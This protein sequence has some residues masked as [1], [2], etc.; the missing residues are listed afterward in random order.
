MLR[1]LAEELR[2]LSQATISVPPTEKGADGTLWSKGEAFLDFAS[3]D[4]LEQ[5]S[6]QRLIRKYVHELEKE[7]IAVSATRTSGGFR[8]VHQLVEERTARFLG[9]EQSVTLTNLPQVALTLVTNLC[10]E[11][12]V[13]LCE[14][15][16]GLPIEDAAY[17]VDAKYYEFTISDPTSY[18]SLLQRS[19]QARR[20]IIFC[21]SVS[22]Y[23][24]ELNPLLPLLSAANAH[25]ALL[26]VDE[27][28]ALGICGSRGAGYNDLFES[29]TTGTTSPLLLQLGSFRRGLGCDGA[30]IA[31]SK[32]VLSLLLARSAALKD[33]AMITPALAAAIAESI[34]E[35]EIKIL[36]R[37]QLL[38]KA[39]RLQSGLEELR[40][41]VV[42]QVFS[43]L[44]SLVFSSLANAEAFVSAMR[45]RGYWLS[46]LPYDQA[47]TKVGIVRCIPRQ[48]HTDLA[49]S[50]F[51]Q[52]A[53]DVKARLD[54]ERL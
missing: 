2:G 19:Q 27:S 11:R 25:G 15:G 8:S 5:A 54:R 40:Y 10:N 4:P 22:S 41:P 42:R 31:G 30:F 24:G 16:V 18:L 3:W 14:R 49:I 52:A 12:D 43:P 6:S 33:G 39:L 1:E 23:T 7:G 21:E 47:N 32:T 26:C 45:S 53:A 20:V 36:V 34:D 37:Q 50:A 29:A 38:Q 9:R 28:S 13:I 44:A 46:C 51:L 35:V 17:L 48:S